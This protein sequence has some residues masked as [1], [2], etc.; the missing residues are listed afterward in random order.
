MSETTTSTILQEPK[1]ESYTAKAFAAQS[2][3]SPLAAT[4][5]SRRKPLPD[6]VEIEILFCGVCHSD[7]HQVRN[8]WENMM[9]TVYPCVPGH[10]VLGFGLPQAA[11]AL[12]RAPGWH[13]RIRSGPGAAYGLADGSAC[14]RKCDSVGRIAQPPWPAPGSDGWQLG[15][16]RSSTWHRR[17]PKGRR[18]PLYPV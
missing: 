15:N 8:E 5:I 10:V 11:R 14:R 3:T 4:S 18:P 17:P 12:P 7:L 6:D 1:A 13:C 2:P 16:W 9:P